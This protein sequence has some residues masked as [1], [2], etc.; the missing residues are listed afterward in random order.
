[1][2]APYFHLGVCGHVSP[3]GKYPS[4]VVP[5]GF[6]HGKYASVQAG[7]DGDPVLSL[8]DPQYGFEEHS[9]QLC[10]Q[11][12]D[13][14][15]RTSGLFAYSRSEVVSFRRTQ[16][17]L[18]LREALGDARTVG[19]DPFVRLSLAYSTQ[20]FASV[21]GEIGR[22]VLSL[23][24]SESPLIA[25]WYGSQREKALFQFPGMDAALPEAHADLPEVVATRTVS[26]WSRKRLR[27]RGE[28][29][30]VAGTQLELS[31]LLFGARSDRSLSYAVKHVSRA[32]FGPAIAC[33]SDYPKA[34][35]RGPR[36][37]S[38]SAELL[39]AECAVSLGHLTSAV[40]RLASARSA[41]QS[42]SNFLDGEHQ[43][44]NSRLASF[45]DH[46]LRKIQEL[47]PVVVLFDAHDEASCRAAKRLSK[48]MAQAVLLE[49][50]PLTMARVSDL[51]LQMSLSIVL[52][53]GSSFASN[54]LFR[55][56][57]RRDTWRARFAEVGMTLP[58]TGGSEISWSKLQSTM[59]SDFREHLAAL[60]LAGGGGGAPGRDSGYEDTP[61]GIST[62]REAI[63]KFGTASDRELMIAD[64]D[65]FRLVEPR[66]I[67]T[68]LPGVFASPEPSLIEILRLEDESGGMESTARRIRA[69]FA[70]F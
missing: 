68:A 9:P 53:V 62:I 47:S 19:S 17:G 12:L 24:A 15:Y 10:D 64:A 65:V 54:D 48:F 28:S 49:A 29:V 13:F 59:G 22:C 66:M 11:L 3:T 70:R 20:D 45:C 23:M 25:R 14:D 43:T 50:E 33:L 39:R 32:E 56:Y 46:R 40:C 42:T 18:F 41:F 34:S 7:P 58:G 60:G 52:I 30:L 16:L 26:E 57:L 37:S 63:G 21:R 31:D 1:M 5:I 44:R 38:G 69:E 67:G 4:V 55:P 6:I 51:A 36:E 35:R 61:S 2:E 27:T 8:F